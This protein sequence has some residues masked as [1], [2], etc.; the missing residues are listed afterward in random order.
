[1]YQYKDNAV[2]FFGRAAYGNGFA[3]QGRVKHLFHSG[4]VLVHINVQNYFTHTPLLQAEKF[5]SISVK[6]LTARCIFDNLYLNLSFTLASIAQLNCTVKMKD[7]HDVR[8]IKLLGGSNMTFGE[9][10][11]QL[12]TEK[13]LS[14]EALAKLMGLSKRTIANYETGNIYP[15]Q[16]SSY[17]KLAD[18]LEVDVN[19]LRTENEVF[20]TEV[21]EKYGRRGQMQA[22]DIIN[23]TQQLFA[24]GSLS[25]EDEMAFV[26]EIQRIFLDSKDKAK[27]KFTPKKYLEDDIGGEQL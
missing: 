8:M 16:Q 25:D 26:M 20:M 23:Q 24:G 1:M 10:V 14:Q 15:R 4:I 9:K 5:F 12:R 7:V 2:P 21:S 3:P 27:K 6:H 19:Y 22:A 17:K 18:I 13:G 11:K